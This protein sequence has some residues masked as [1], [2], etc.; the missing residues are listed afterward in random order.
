MSMR[1]GNTVLHSFTM[2]VSSGKGRVRL[3]PKEFA[4]LE[5]LMVR[6]NRV[7]SVDS[8]LAVLQFSSKR[9]SLT[10]LHT[11]LYNIRLALL[12]IGSNLSIEPERGVG[13]ILWCRDSPRV[14]EE[15]TDRQREA[16]QRCIEIASQH[17]PEIAAM[18]RGE[19]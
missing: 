2:E 15:Y 3:R 10:N 16:V 8:I 14:V 11:R 4:V 6:S 19:A 12:K 13:F 1:L 7:L 17:N 9:P 5:F 18:A